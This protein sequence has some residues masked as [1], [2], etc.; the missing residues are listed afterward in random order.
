MQGLGPKCRT[1]LG[2][3]ILYHRT[4]TNDNS[5]FHEPLWA[6]KGQSQVC[7]GTCGASKEGPSP[8]SAHVPNASALPAQPF[9]G[10]AWG[11]AD[12]SKTSTS[13]DTEG[14]LVKK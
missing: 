2:C 10:R 1:P 14:C 4:S 12:R 7:M 6:S 9:K 13:P 8:T 11:Q 3:F 5:L